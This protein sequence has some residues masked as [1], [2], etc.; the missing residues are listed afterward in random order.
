MTEKPGFLPASAQLN[1]SASGPLW[2]QF[3]GVLPQV[4]GKIRPRNRGSRGYMPTKSLFHGRKP[5]LFGRMPDFSP[6]EKQF[7]VG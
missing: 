2:P 5:P 7:H 1:R 4:E 3:C 6:E